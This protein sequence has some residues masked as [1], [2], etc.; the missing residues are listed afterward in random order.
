[1][2]NKVYEMAKARGVHDVRAFETP[3][4]QVRILKRDANTKNELSL[5]SA[6]MKRAAERPIVPFKKLLDAWSA[7]DPAA[8]ASIAFDS[9]SPEE[10]QDDTR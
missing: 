1:M 10:K 8:I 3:E 4:F 6:A 2:D 7:G 9:M 5:L